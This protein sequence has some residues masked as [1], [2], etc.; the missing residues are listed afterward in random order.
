[1]TQRLVS[2][3]DTFTPPAAFKVADANLPERLGTAALNAT[4]VPAAVGTP[5]SNNA[6]AIA[7][8]A[9][10]KWGES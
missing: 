10:P 5:T 9:A 4:Y 2:V 8:L 1:M 6:T 3:D 7:S